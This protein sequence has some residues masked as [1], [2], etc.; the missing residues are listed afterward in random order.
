[1]AV[2]GAVFS[3]SVAPCNEKELGV[4]PGR[5]PEISHGNRARRSASELSASGAS[6][7]SAKCSPNVPALSSRER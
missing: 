3:R 4:G 5:K 1:M 7:N 2:R 6:N